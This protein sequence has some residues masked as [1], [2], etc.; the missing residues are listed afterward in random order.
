MGFKCL[1]EYDRDGKPPLA[2]LAY[3]CDDPSDTSDFIEE[4]FDLAKWF[5]LQGANPLR[6]FR[7]HDICALHVAARYGAIRITK[8]E[9]FTQQ[10]LIAY[11]IDP[12]VLRNLTSN[13]YPYSVRVLNPL[14]SLFLQNA[15]RDRY[16]VVADDLAMDVPQQQSW[17]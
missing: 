12:V 5:F 16:D 11:W 2:S 7:D 6:S 8:I 1:D 3:R 14:T 15:G 10:R 9:E 17:W 13:S 4:L